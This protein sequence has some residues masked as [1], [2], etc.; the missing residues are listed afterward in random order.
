MLTSP[1]EEGSS[2]EWAVKEIRER[3]LKIN[4]GNFIYIGRQGVA[5][6]YTI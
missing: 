3:R 5:S 4:V 6:G 2:W 1:K